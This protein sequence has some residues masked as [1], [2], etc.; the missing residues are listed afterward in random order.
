MTIMTL[1]VVALQVD[2]QCVWRHK[3]ERKVKTLTEDMESVTSSTAELMTE[4][5]EITGNSL[6]LHTVYKHRAT[7]ADGL[8]L[9]GLARSAPAH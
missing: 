8:S 6:G 9:F 2:E 7:Q 5:E 3:G 4:G 1:M